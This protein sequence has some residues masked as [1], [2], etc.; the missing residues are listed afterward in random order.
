MATQRRI[1]NAEK[2]HL[3]ADEQPAKSDI[4]PAVPPSVIIKLLGF[5]FAM[6]TFPISAYFLTRDFLFSGNSTFA[7]ATAA[8]VANVVLI[9]YVVV[10]FKDDASERAEEEEKEKKKSR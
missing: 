2:T 1:I 10:A 7:G 5:T 8:V 4:K 6:V 3:D 9:A